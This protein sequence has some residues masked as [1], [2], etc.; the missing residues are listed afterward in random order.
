MILMCLTLISCSKT[1]VDDNTSS[2]NSIIS[3]DTAADNSTVD[4]TN[5]G[6]TSKQDEKNTYDD[7][8]QQIFITFFKFID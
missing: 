8:D 3:N 5:E 6:N 7:P 1:T 4:N 2:K